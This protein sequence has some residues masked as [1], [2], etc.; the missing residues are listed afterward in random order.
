MI[1]EIFRSGSK[2]HPEAAENNWEH[3]RGY[4]KWGVRFR[5]FFDRGL[6]VILRL[7]KIIQSTGGYFKWG[8]RFRR[9]FDQCLRVILRPRK[10][11]QITLGGNFRAYETAIFFVAPNYPF[12]H[13]PFYHS[14][15]CL[16]LRKIIQITLGG[17]FRAYETAIFFVAQT[18][19][20]LH[21]PFY[22]SESCLRLRKKNSDHFEGYF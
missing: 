3:F 9:F 7:R 18:Y 21:Y 4:F 12:L 16:R 17:I 8:V 2:S 6:R 14:E 20:L 1:L 19:P 22:H 10:I 5:R 11:I 15:S 13:Y